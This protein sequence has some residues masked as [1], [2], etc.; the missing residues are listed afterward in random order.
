VSERE[1]DTAQDRLADVT[2][3]KP[4]RLS[5]THPWVAPLL[6]T[7]GV[8]A[9]ASFLS[10]LPPTVAPILTA[11]RSVD[12]ST[13]GYLSAMN[14][15]GAMIF[16]LAGTPLM[17]RAGSVRTLQIGL[18]LGA[19][20]VAMMALPSA[21]MLL[22]A[23]LLMG[24]GYG[25][26]SPAGSDI[27]HRYVPKNR[28]ALVFSI[29]QA[30]VPLGGIVAGFVLPPLID[31]GGLVLC[32]VVSAVIALVAAVVVQPVRKQLDPLE[33]NGPPLKLAHFFS[34][35]NLSRPIRCL[36]DTPGLVRLAMTGLALAV[37]QGIW[38]AFLVTIL[39]EQAGLS[40]LAAGSLF[41]IMQVTSVIGRIG[42]GWVAD[43]VGSSTATLQGAAAFSAVCT[44][45]LAFV[46]AQTPSLLVTLLCAVAGAT[47]TGWNGVQ[48]AEVARLSK[49][50]Q[51]RETSAGATL[52]LFTAY[53]VGPAAF[54]LAAQLLGSYLLPLLGVAAL[55]ALSAFIPRTSTTRP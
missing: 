7:V 31:I 3:P 9:V 42:L 16:L 6:L 19:V 13:I 35:A 52:L 4:A 49:P 41:A 18:V 47:V 32:L 24:L 20:G 44:V 43:R 27:L 17:D 38:I 1:L 54:A 12:S 34:P 46:G 30:G 8:Q 10:R 33:Q 21:L 51:I 2:R 55:T 36:L 29:K 22:P 15:A 26:S 50:G 5:S 48:I 40:L 23:V 28:H 25:P 45:A 37:S 11:E 39:V 53:V 14:T